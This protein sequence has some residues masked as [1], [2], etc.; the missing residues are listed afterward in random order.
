MKTSQ[1][2]PQWIQVIVLLLLIWN[3]MGIA[4]FVLDLSIDPST[5]DATQQ[6]F[7]S[8]FPLW[9][10]IIYGLAVGLGTLGTLGLMQRKL[11]SKNLLVFSLLF[12]IIQMYH[13][14]F[15]AGGLEIFG[16]SVAIMPTVVIILS[17][18]L[19]WLAQ[20]FGR[21]GWLH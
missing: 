2:P 19:V 20:L 21:K 4:F 15:I 11:W 16:S 3:F 6:E 5:L 8:R 18:V 10:K 17:L 14:L 9:T 13:S 12:V 1:K 7:R